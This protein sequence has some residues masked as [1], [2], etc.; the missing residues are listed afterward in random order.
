L[1]T[2]GK[3]FGKKKAL[4]FE[5]SVVNVPRSVVFSESFG[6]EL[7]IRKLEKSGSVEGE[8]V[9]GVVEEDTAWSNEIEFATPIFADEADW[10]GAEDSVAWELPVLTTV[11][12]AHDKPL[13]TGPMTINQMEALLPESVRKALKDHLRGEFR[14][15]RTYIQGR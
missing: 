8:S 1:C 5:L 15:I 14:E 9:T 2:H 11:T 4:E 12:S 10:A 7:L 13:E 3:R 6:F